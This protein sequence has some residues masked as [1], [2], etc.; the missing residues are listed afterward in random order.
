M[1]RDANEEGKITQEI[2]EKGTSI[3]SGIVRKEMT[4]EDDGRG[5]SICSRII[6]GNEYTVEL[7]L[8]M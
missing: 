6:D 1:T 5:I 7:P 2:D 3:R 8:R 4:Q